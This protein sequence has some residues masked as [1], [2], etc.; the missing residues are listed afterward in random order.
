[1]TELSF[2]SSL[3]QGSVVSEIRCMFRYCIKLGPY[4]D[5]KQF[6]LTMKQIVSTYC[7]VLKLKTSK[8]SRFSDQIIDFKVLHSEIVSMP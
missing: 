3:G 8:T 7:S 1:M 4:A 5:L 6:D 2:E